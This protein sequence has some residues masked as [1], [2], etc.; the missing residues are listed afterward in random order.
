MKK[1]VLKYITYIRNQHPASVDVFL[2][3]LC[4]HFFQILQSK[5]PGAEAYYNSDHV[6]TKI[7]G[8]YYDITGKVKKKKTHQPMDEHYPRRMELKRLLTAEDYL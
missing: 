6:I 1:D 5:F 4:F 8:H 2:N 7:G 3:G